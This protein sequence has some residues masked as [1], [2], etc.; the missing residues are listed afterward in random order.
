MAFEGSAFLSPAPTEALQRLPKCNLH[1][2]L[3]GSVRPDT[4]WELAQEQ[5]IDLGLPRASMESALQVDGSE[6]NLV[7]YLAKISVTY[8]VLKRPAALER[9]A[10]EA[11]EDAARDGV[12]YFELRAGPLTHSGSGL[13]VERVLESMLA[14]LKR[15]EAEHGLVCRL[16]VAAL[17]HHDP[18]DNLRLAQIAAD[19]RDQGVVGFDLAGDE[20]GYPAQLH[21]P[22]FDAARR[23]GLGITLHAGE[24]AG[25]ENVRYAVEE[26]GATRIGHGVRSIESE[27]VLGLLRQRGTLLEV[28]PTSNIHTRAVAGLAQHPVRALYEREIKISIGDDDPITSRTRVSRELALL[29]EAFAFSLDELRAIQKMGLEGAF[30]TDSEL[31]ARLLLAL[32][33]G[34]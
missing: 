15:A 14:G 26:L 9:T 22:A 31:R 21:R 27:A 8:Q 1:S 6:R 20:A 28:C 7:D 30:V 32:Q 10:Y 12:I 34:A 3:E 4:L 5:G 11:A 19:F 33:A 24:A 18:Q 23:A 13:P 2:H 29:A 16:I 17:R 25:A